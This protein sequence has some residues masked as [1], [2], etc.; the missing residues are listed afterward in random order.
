MRYQMRC[1]YEHR[2]FDIVSNEYLYIPVLQASEADIAM[3]CPRCQREIY[4]RII[5]RRISGTSALEK[6]T[7]PASPSGEPGAF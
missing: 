2:L 3:K 5:N 4:I 6:Q 1:K 7:R